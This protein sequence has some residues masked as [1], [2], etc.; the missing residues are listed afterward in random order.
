MLTADGGIDDATIHGN[1]ARQVI[2]RP[3]AVAL[4]GDNSCLTYAELDE[5]S[6]RLANHLRG[7][8]VGR[9]ALVGTMLRRSP[10]SIVAL[11]AIL[12]VGAAYVPFDPAYPQDLLFF[13]LQDSSPA[14]MIVQSS[15]IDAIG[16]P[17]FW[18]IPTVCM[19]RD[20]ERLLRTSATTLPV[21]TVPDDLAY[22]MYT[23]GSTGRPKGVMIPHRGVV[24]LVKDNDYASFGQAEVFLHLAPLT[25]DACTFEI[26]G[27]LLN[28]ARLAVV[29][30]IQPSLEEIA[31]AIGT[32]G[33]TTMWLTAG[34]F[35]LMVDHKLDALRS[36][37][38]LLAGG[39]VLSPSHVQK[40]LHALPDCRLINGYGPT[41]NTTFTCCYR[42]P[43][44]QTP[45]KPIPIGNAIRHTSVYVLDEDLSP[46]A[47]GAVGQLCTGGQGVALG[48]LNRDVLTKQKF[49]ADPFAARP[50]ALMYLTGDLV[51]VAPDGNLEFLGRADRQVK[52]NG[53]RVELEEIE[54]TLRNCDSVGDAVAVGRES[55]ATTKRIDAYVTAKAGHSPT[56]DELRSHLRARLPDH[57]IPNTIAVLDAFPLLPS[58][59][60]DR[61]ALPQPAATSTRAVDKPSLPRTELEQALTAIWQSVLGTETIGV[62]DN[63][64]DLGGSSLQLIEVQERIQQQ[65]ACKLDTVE[66][67]RFSRIRLLAA[68]ISGAN[69]TPAALRGVRQRALRQ[70][71]AIAAMRRRAGVR[72]DAALRDSR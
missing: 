59:K 50:G 67:F 29:Q 24:R 33:V 72:R 39:D 14:A 17:S 46:V 2:Q 19:E 53:K 8:G 25:F 5:R 44:A 18:N 7:L 13:M 71:N 22:V 35:N 55:N 56:A 69:A 20:A 30:S 16:A 40:V 47:T 49:I 15:V 37:R 64:F 26:W 45:G 28:G 23:S 52:I 4:I 63:F 65:F 6:N 34:L 1:F 11:L 43:A 31:E 32:N 38:Q 3:E 9:G 62:D 21:M 27:A 10:D 70:G 66:M 68:H 57:M 60:I 36:V 58:G 61:N 51:R 42:V 48:Y 12:K 54:E 41:E